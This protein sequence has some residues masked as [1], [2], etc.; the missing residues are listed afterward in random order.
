MVGTFNTID[1][2]QYLTSGEHTIV[3][4][5]ATEQRS[6]II[7]VPVMVDGK[8][9][10]AVGVSLFLDKLSGQINAALDLRP[11]VAFSHW[12]RMA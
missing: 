5:K 4:S 10:G 9:V 12:P 8:V 6:T 1:V 3:I 2:S 7:A 11:G